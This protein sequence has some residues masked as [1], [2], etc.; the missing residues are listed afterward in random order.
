MVAEAITTCSSAQYTSACSSAARMAIMQQ[1]LHLRRAPPSR[2]LVSSRAQTQQTAGRLPSATVITSWAYPTYP[3]STRANW[4]SRMRS[5]AALAHCFGQ[6][7]PPARSSSSSTLQTAAPSH[8]PSTSTNV[9]RPCG[10]CLTFA[11]STPIPAHPPSR[12][13]SVPSGPQ[14]RNIPPCLCHLG[15]LHHCSLYPACAVNTRVIRRWREEPNQRQV[16]HRATTLLTL[17]TSTSSSP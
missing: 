16:G 17:P 9:M 4:L 2:F 13:R 10:S 3:L 5:F 11:C 14:L 12:S 7:T 6:H 8:H 15:W 1:S